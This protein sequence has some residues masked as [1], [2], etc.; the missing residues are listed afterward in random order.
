MALADKLRNV[1]KTL[2]LR[3]SQIGYLA[4][5]RGM[6]GGVKSVAPR[7]CLANTV[8]PAVMSES[9]RLCGPHVATLGGHAD[10]YNALQCFCHRQTFDL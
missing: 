2:K 1:Q 6:L 10:S 4:S 9:I 5:R 7:A 8:R 3:M